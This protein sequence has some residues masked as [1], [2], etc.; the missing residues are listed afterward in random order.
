M[1]RPSVGKNA[2]FTVNDENT[3]DLSI[4]NGLWTIESLKEIFMEMF[5]EQQNA[6][7]SNTSAPTPKPTPLQ[8]S[9]DKMTME[10]KDNNDRLNNTM[11]ETHDLKLS[12]ETY[13]KVNRWQTQG[14]SIDKTK[15]SFK[16]EIEKS[17]KD[18]DDSNNELRILEDRSR[19]DS[20]RFH[21]IEE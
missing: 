15:E 18:N 16:R 4:I 19:R 7:V 8:K 21:R 14:N 13:Q 17:K 5:K 3:D 2:Y 11:K 6:L 10:I 1:N 12:V 20:L 9:L